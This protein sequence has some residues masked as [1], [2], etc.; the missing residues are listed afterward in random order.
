MKESIGL[1][2]LG[3][4]G[5]NLARNFADHG[6]TV[7]A[8]NRW[9]DETERF[10]AEK[11]PSAI[12][13]QPDLP[14]LVASLP[15]P[16]RILLMVS[17]GE[18]VDWVIQAL[19]PL[20]SPGDALA[21]GGN[22]HWQDTERRANS[23]AEAG[24]HFLGL[25]VS[26]G[27][28]GAR[29]GPSLMAGGSREAWSAFSRPLQEIAARTDDGGSCGGLLGPGGAGHGAK[30][31]H[32]GI[33][34][35]QMQLLAEADLLLEASGKQPRERASILETW[36]G[37]LLDGF[38]LT[39]TI[40]SLLAVDGLSGLP[41]VE[42]IADRSGQKGTGTWTVAAALEC[43]V[44]VP[45]LA[46]SL[47]ARG[48][49]G[50]TALRSSLT[51]LPV[52]RLAPEQ[53]GDLEQALVASGLLS[54][55]QGLDLLGSLSQ[56]RGW[57]DVPPLA[58]RLWAQGCI[59]RGRMRG[60]VQEA[61]ERVPAGCSPLADMALAQR[62]AQA[63]PALRRTVENAIRASIP[64]PALS[65]ALWHWDALAAPRV[66]ADLIQAQ[67][68]RFGSHGFERTDRSGHHH[69]DWPKEP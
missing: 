32:N 1:V 13:V 37:G 43:G 57:G 18:P 34:Y 22:S 61:L 60:E 16:R 51:G 39:V 67:R 33:E 19:R 29:L 52:K 64:V 23:L 46:L 17:A 20:L 11:L 40:E 59:L 65:S 30:M 47:F 24:I 41:L 10:L 31:V 63:I 45:T 14:T 68:D 25:G 69:H 44:P 3:A 7:L 6:M 35:A 58:C 12:Q 53:P 49:S 66:G 2:G 4:M 48:M 28:E 9:P 54:W 56:R 42:V 50:Q 5:S 62:V 21:D 26:G 38:L 36:S 27:A 55:C 8:W 15:R